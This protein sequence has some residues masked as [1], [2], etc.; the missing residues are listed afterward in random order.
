MP[1][2]TPYASRPHLTRLELARYLISFQ[3]ELS[4]TFSLQASTPNLR[5]I[6]FDALHFGGILS[7]ISYQYR[8]YP[9]YKIKPEHDYG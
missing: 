7:R 6:S 3:S 4:R 9:V 5:R 2:Q 8:S 1:L